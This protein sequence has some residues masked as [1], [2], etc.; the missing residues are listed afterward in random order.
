MYICFF[1]LT[2]HYYYNIAYDKYLAVVSTSF[3]NAFSKDK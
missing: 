3:I 2:Y 1:K